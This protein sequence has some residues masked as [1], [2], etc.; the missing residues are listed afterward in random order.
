MRGTGMILSALEFVRSASR[1]TLCVLIGLGCYALIPLALSLERTAAFN[2][3]A[4]A[5]RDLRK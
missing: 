4:E 3:I 1:E 5:I 2:R